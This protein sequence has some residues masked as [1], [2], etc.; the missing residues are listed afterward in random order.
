MTGPIGHDVR[1]TYAAIRIE[2]HKTPPSREMVP[3]RRRGKNDTVYYINFSNIFQG[4][5]KENL[6]K[7]I[8]KF[9]HI[10]PLHFVLFCEKK[11]PKKGLTNVF[12]CDIIGGCTKHDP[13]A[14]S[15]EHLTFNQGVRGSSLRWVTKAKGYCNAV[16]FCFDRLLKET[17]SIRRFL[18]RFF[19]L[20]AD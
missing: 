17:R 1:Q 15:V 3:F 2:L 9:Y 6:K 18:F 12:G 7:S 10:S 13:L 16:P 5:W 4:V 11:F 19:S 8:T 14:Q 20:G